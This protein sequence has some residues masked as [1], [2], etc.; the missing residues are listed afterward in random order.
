MARV[1]GFFHKEEVEQDADIVIKSRRD[2]VQGFL[3]L[4][5]ISVE[6]RPFSPQC[7][8]QCPGA[9]SS[10]FSHFRVSDHYLI[11]RV[12]GLFASHFLWSRHT[13]S[14]AKPLRVL[15]SSCLQVRP[16]PNHFRR[17]LCR[18]CLEMGTSQGGR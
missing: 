7:L 16:I 1:L 18:L 5:A 8:Q 6:S 4:S 11:L 17:Q 13:A 15:S 2:R 9:F 14:R 3:P 12:P 10:F